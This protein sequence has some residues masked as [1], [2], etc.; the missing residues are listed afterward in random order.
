MARRRGVTTALLAGALLLAGCAQQGASTQGQD[1]HDLYV[2]I[3]I[4]ATPVFVGVEAYLLWCVF[5]Y[6]KR[7]DRPAPQDAGSGRALVVFFAVPTVIIAL[8][9]PFG[10][11]TLS[12]VQHREKNPGVTINVEAFQWQWTFN[13][14]NEG[15][16]SSGKTLVK[17]AVME[18]PVN[19]TVHIH[20]ESRDVMHEFYVPALLFMRNAL[21]GHPNDFDF[22]P[23]E[24]GTF[25]GQCAEFCG[26]WH[27][28]MTFVLKVVT[29]AEYA[30]WIQ[31]EKQAALNVSCPPGPPTVQLVAQNTAWD[32]NCIA[33]PANTPL[34][35]V[36]DNKDVGIDH[37]FAVFDSPKRKVK[38]YE[39]EPITGPATATLQ[40]KPLPPGRYYFECTIH[41][42]SMA[43]TLIVR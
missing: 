13:Y 11:Q 7:D 41:G 38:D 42:P 39:S 20:L 32:T 12:Y 14:V 18:V 23:I 15:L 17:P 31:S 1:I 19:Q 5:R 35:V 34:S 29:P 21:P 2:R 3:V 28:K 25:P 37:T 33:V 26:L 30:A 40:I 4:L 27:S 22:T 9:F 24:L 10:E 16:V 36:M 8:L 43:G 6:R